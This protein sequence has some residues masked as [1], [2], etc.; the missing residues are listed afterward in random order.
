MFNL[1]LNFSNLFYSLLEKINELN[2]IW[3]EQGIQFIQSITKLLE[4]LLDYRYVVDGE[5]NRDKRMSCT[6]N[7]LHF[8]KNEINRKEMYIRY[9]YK[10]CALHIPAENYTEAAFT[11]KLHSD[12]LEWSWNIIPTFVSTS[13]ATGSGSNI[14][15][16]REEVEWKRKEILYQSIIEYFDRGKCWEEGIPLLKELAVFYEKKLFDY[17]KL[18]TVLVRIFSSSI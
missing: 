10:L 4:L 13:I 3:K 15:F 5:D 8:Y 11:L 16:G 9:I 2:P 1:N 12:L 7:L 18:S 6:V 17:Q 14:C